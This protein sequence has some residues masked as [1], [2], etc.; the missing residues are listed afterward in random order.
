MSLAE[1]AALRFGGGGSGLSG[2]YL[3]DQVLLP[4]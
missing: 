1:A 3:A 2:G 4:G